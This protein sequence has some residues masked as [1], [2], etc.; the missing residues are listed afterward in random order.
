MM[1]FVVIGMKVLKKYVD[2]FKEVNSN[3]RFWIIYFVIMNY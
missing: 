2:F 3:L 1:V